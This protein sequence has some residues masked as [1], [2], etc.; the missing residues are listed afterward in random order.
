MEDCN[1]PLERMHAASVW[2]RTPCMRHRH[3]WQC[4]TPPAPLGLGRAGYGFATTF[5]RPTLWT[6]PFPASIGLEPVL[7]EDDGSVGFR[8]VALSEA[9]ARSGLAVLT[10]MPS[11]SLSTSAIG[12]HAVGCMHACEC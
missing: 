2:E 4:L 7:P 3:A 9:E 10:C 5:V 11:S 6:D 8:E 1:L 12:L